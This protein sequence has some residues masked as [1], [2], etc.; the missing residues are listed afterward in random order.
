MDLTKRENFPRIRAVYFGEQ[1]RVKKNFCLFTT[2]VHLVD[3]CFQI[4]LHFFFWPLQIDRL[5]ICHDV[6]D[7]SGPLMNFVH[8]QEKNISMRKLVNPNKFFL[9]THVAEKL[10]CFLHVA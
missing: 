7:R 5:S 1:H 3:F 4:K 8:S 6:Y 2:E 9:L 10:V